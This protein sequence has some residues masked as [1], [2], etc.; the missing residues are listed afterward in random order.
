MKFFIFFVIS[1]I[2]LLPFFLGFYSDDWAVLI[3]PV[4][5]GGSWTAE[6][7]NFCLQAFNFR[8]I[9]AVILF[10]FSSIAGWSIF[11]W[12]LIISGLMLVTLYVLEK[13]VRIILGFSQTNVNRVT[14]FFLASLFFIF[15]WN[16]G[17]FF[18]TTAAISVV[19]SLLLFLISILSM[20]KFLRAINYR[21][22]VVGCIFYILSCLTYEAFY[23]QYL[24]FFLMFV[25]FFKTKKRAS[26]FCV[27]AYSLAFVLAFGANRYLSVITHSTQAKNLSPVWLPVLARSLVTWPG[28]I[29]VTY[30]G[31]YSF[32]FA[33]ASAMVLVLVKTPKTK[34]NLALKLGAFLFLGIGIGLVVYSLVGYEIV[35]RGIMSRTTIVISSYLLLGLVALSA[36]IKHNKLL[37]GLVTVTLLVGF[38]WR[39]K[40]WLDAWNLQKYVV[41]H[42]S[43]ARSLIS[44][45]DSVVIYRGPV[46]INGVSVFE[47]EYDIE[48]AVNYVINKDNGCLMYKQKCVQRYYAVLRPNFTTTWD[49]HEVFQYEK[50]GNQLW[51]I[52]SGNIWVW[53]I[54]LNNLTKINTIGVIL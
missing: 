43:Q 11:L 20:A 39:S 52:K 53:D 49:G 40:D 29:L 23:L 37:L 10:A 17:S 54:N 38:L 28:I 2:I 12:H 45:P 1:L 21:Y 42:M 34:V 51:R 31:I 8:P 3:K 48:G 36:C 25:F 47:A 16:L 35:A 41:Q 22:L 5:Y 19:T 44:D 26:W 46:S 14:S 27:L 6:R 13:L 50:T 4:Y 7:L 33:L 9:S 24:P 30:Q 18:F 15:P 32:F